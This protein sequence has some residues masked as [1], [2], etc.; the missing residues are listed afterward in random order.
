M[1]TMLDML[2]FEE[3]NIEGQIDTLITRERGDIYVV[4]HEDISNAI[5][6]GDSA[7]AASLMDAHIDKLMTAVQEQIQ[8]MPQDPSEKAASLP[9]SAN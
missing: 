2:I 7:Q 1:K 4:E 5:A 9:G 6:A 8:L 3:R